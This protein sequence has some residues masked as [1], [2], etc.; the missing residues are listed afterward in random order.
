M[1]AHLHYGGGTL[2]ETYSSRPFAVAARPRLPERTPLDVPVSKDQI[3]LMCPTLFHEDLVESHGTHAARINAPLVGV[4]VVKRPVTGTP[5]VVITGYGSDNKPEELW[6]SKT[7]ARL[8]DLHKK[9]LA[10]PHRVVGCERGGCDC[11]TAIAQ[12]QADRRN[13]LSRLMNHK[14]RRGI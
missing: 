6:C 9:G 12:W 5:A 3:V 8:F 13:E 14:S 1:N 10:Q 4:A 11:G 2:T 7:N